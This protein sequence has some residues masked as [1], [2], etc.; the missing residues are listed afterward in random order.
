MQL[1]ELFRTGGIPFMKGLEADVWLQFFAHQGDS[2]SFYGG[3]DLIARIIV[4]F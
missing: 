1:S 3:N 4:V 2:L